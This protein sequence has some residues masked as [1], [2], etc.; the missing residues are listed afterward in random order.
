MAYEK[1]YGTLIRIADRIL[2]FNEGRI[3]AD[4]NHAELYE[5]CMLYRSLYD[6]QVRTATETGKESSES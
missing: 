6:E 5:Q 4:G 1:S 3:V 2:V